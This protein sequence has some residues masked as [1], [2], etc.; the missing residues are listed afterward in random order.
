MTMKWPVAIAALAVLFGVGHALAAD[1]EP[2]ALV[3]DAPST[4]PGMAAFFGQITGRTSKVRAPSAGETARALHVRVAQSA[5]G[6]IGH[7][8]FEDAGT[9]SSPRAVE[10]KTCGEV[11]EALGLIAA[12]AVDPKAS[13]ALPAAP[14][15]PAPAADAEAPPPIDAAAPE[16]PPVAPVEPPPERH[17]PPGRPPPSMGNH[18]RFGVGVG[19][20]GSSLAGFLGAGR[21]F[22]DVSARE[23]S[24]ALLA[25][26]LRGAFMRSL[27]AEQ[28]PQV[29]SATLRWTVG[30]L[31]GCPI[32]W[33][34]ASMLSLRPCAAFAAGVVSADAT[35]VTAARQRSRLWMAADLDGRL[36]WELLRYLDLELEV[37]VRAP[38]T[39]ETFF[40]QPGV[41]V[42][43]APFAAVFGRIGA[44]VRF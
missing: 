29:G 32:R 19:I 4:C 18:L 15:A 10:G 44:A 40:F 16:P 13:I 36:A 27:D 2:L 41:E 1:A 35:G 6:F 12:L 11:V 22:V 33:E 37:G 30:A 8:H 23:R 42:Y 24:G 20:E 25:P 34:L 17:E 39:R 21:L 38:L 28:S 43:Q 26:S 7:L 31:E 5:G 3:Y 14:A 9:K